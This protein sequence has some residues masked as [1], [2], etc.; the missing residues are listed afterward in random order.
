[1]RMAATMP[2]GA[3]GNF[4]NFV[5]QQFLGRESIANR[6][7]TPTFAFTNPF[8]WANFIRSVK[9]GDYKSKEWRAQYNQAPPENI[10]RKDLLDQSN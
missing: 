9:R 8:A 4:Q 7:F 3:V 5:N 10:S 1:M 6:G 2:M